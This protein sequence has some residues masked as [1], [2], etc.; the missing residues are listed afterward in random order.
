LSSRRRCAFT[1]I[2]L[3]VVI[4][5]V[6]LLASLLLPALSRAKEKSRSAVCRNNLYQLSL[7]MLLYSDENFEYLP[8]PIEFENYEPAWCLVEAWPPAVPEPLPLHA[9]GGSVFA[10]VTGQ[11]R[12]ALPAS[13][14]EHGP[15]V[16]PDRAC[17][18]RFRTYR[19]PSSGS[20]G[21]VNRVTYSMNHFLCPCYTD[22]VGPANE[23]GVGRW[24]VL[25]PSEKV[26]LIDK[27]YEMACEAEACG[28]LVHN[29]ISTNQI[30]HQ[31]MLNLVFLDGH[32]ESFSQTKA[33]TIETNEALLKRYLLP[34]E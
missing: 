14:G 24:T 34:F 8:W 31:G 30:R 26:L 23:R 15:R 10:Y 9:E 20:L 18:T 13:M 2:E 16:E 25:S 1:L 17:T 6:G 4:A 11:P 3:L 27:T 33:L 32:L 21:V 7:G 28:G 12:V 22:V 29:L 19:C 5:I